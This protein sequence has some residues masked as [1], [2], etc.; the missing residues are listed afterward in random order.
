MLGMAFPG[1][2]HQ[3]SDKQMEAT[4]IEYEREG[5]QRAET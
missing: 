3:H 5:R 2:A 1:R 4:W